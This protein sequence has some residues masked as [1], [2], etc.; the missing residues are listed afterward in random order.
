MPT[1]TSVRAL[2]RSAGLVYDVLI[3]MAV[4]RWM[5]PPSSAAKPSMA[6]A[7]CSITWASPTSPATDARAGSERIGGVG[8]VVQALEE[9]ALGAMDLILVAVKRSPDS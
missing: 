2:G 4:A 7:S 5:R 8:N 9:E 3:R 1:S 6:S